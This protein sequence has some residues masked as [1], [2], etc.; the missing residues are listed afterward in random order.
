[1]ISVIENVIQRGEVGHLKALIKI[2]MNALTETGL[3]AP[4]NL[5]FELQRIPDRTGAHKDADIKSKADI[6]ENLRTALKER[7][8]HSEDFELN[9]AEPV[10]VD[11]SF[12]RIVARANGKMLTIID[13][14]IAFQA[15]F[16]FFEKDDA[17]L[18]RLLGRGFSENIAAGSR[19]SYL[20]YFSPALLIPIFHGEKINPLLFKDGI[21]DSG[22]QKI[23]DRTYSIVGHD[24]G[25]RGTHHE[26]I[27]MGQFL[28]AHCKTDSIHNT[29]LV[30]PFFYPPETPS[31]PDV[32]FVLESENQH[33]PVF[34]QSKISG[35]LYPKD[36]SDA[37]RTVCCESIEA[38]LSL[39]PL[40]SSSNP[41][42]L[43]DFCSGGIFFS[44]L[45]LPNCERSSYSVAKP[46]EVTDSSG[47]TLTQ[48]TIIIDKD[49]METLA[50]PEVVDVLKSAIN[51]LK[52]T[53][54]D[55]QVMEHE[56][57]VSKPNSTKKR[58]V[59]KKSADEA[60]VWE[61]K[62]GQQIVE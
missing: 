23:L 32:V 52:R 20:E 29:K 62:A 33:Y 50:S 27:S 25:L 37:H 36:I 9:Y 1:M 3:M 17:G 19:G 60:E 10:L 43:A 42:S 30:A 46:K 40:P 22:T 18:L 16:N 13:E 34:I 11:A 31:G 28:Y 8:F 49:N 21:K 38:H 48:Y 53:V 15:A 58:K 24:T 57:G 59:Q 2:Q 54:E 35:S 41:P 5:C 44:L 39:P 12:A 6:R 26:K 51:P 55:I 61:M 4:G 56:N 7:L 45:L 47:R 14:P